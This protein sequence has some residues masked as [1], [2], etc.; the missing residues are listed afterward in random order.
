M[1]RFLVRRF[2]QAIPT[3]LGISLVSF[4]LILLAPGDA[5]RLRAFGVPN[6]TPADLAA[7]R[8]VYGLDRPLPL[9]YLSWLGR[10]AQGDFGRSILYQRPALELR[11]LPV[12]GASGVGPGAGSLADRLLHLLGPV[13]TPGLAGMAGYVRLARVG[14]L[15]VLR[16]DFIRTA[17]A[18]GLSQAAV[19]GRH[20]LRHAL[21]PV[22]TALGGALPWLVSGSLVVEQVFA[23]PGVGRLAFE[24]ARAKD[25][26]VVMAVVILTSV[27]LLLGYLLRDLCYALA[28]PRIRHE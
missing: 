25:Y 12:G 8:E 3:L 23:W 14:A 16:E 20:V 13:L 5:A 2:L 15:E 6:V 22:I 4:A 26:P 28:D 1:P 27:A 21:L 11:L 7:L 9:Q 19:L 18:K 17:H 10:V 24:A